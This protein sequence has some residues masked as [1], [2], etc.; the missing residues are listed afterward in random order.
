MFQTRIHGRGG[1]GVVTAAELL[2][3]AAFD[4]G[5]HAQ[6]FPSFGSE[7]TGAPVVA[8]CRIDDSP[9]RTREPI[10]APDA[11]I[12]Q[13]VTLLGQVDVLAGLPE[14]AYV[15]INSASSISDLG[16]DEF[17]ADHRPERVMTAPATLLAKEHIGRPVPNVALLGGFA[18]L[19]GQVT[20]D[21]LE[22][23]VAERFAGALVA[24]NQAAARAAYDYVNA[25][26]TVGEGSR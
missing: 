5:H 22:L 3:V 18:A 12:I 17:L 10:V 21:A 23:A 26:I 24:G 13:D 16:L 19:T 4:A 2:S 15:L 9:I 6:A 14:H 20:L 1:Q 8:Y 11:L 25:A 7:R